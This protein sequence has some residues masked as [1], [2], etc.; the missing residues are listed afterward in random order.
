MANIF[1]LPE[2]DIITYKFVFQQSNP[3][4]LN[5]SAV[6]TTQTTFLFGMPNQYAI[7]AV[8]INPLIAVTGTDLATMTCS[9]GVS[10]STA[11][12]APAFSIMQSS[13][14]QISSPLLQY[15]VTAH[16][17]NATL[18]STGAN[19]SVASAGEFEIVVQIRPLP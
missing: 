14:V 1:T 17:V 7:C 11:Y 18:L 6:A 12:Y 19:I 10:G 9:L 5:F 15:Q 4:P 3:A 13:S 8:K 16:D 2:S